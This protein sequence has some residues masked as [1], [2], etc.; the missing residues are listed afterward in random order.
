MD[1]LPDVVHRR[2]EGTRQE[3]PGTDGTPVIDGCARDAL[4][5]FVVVRQLLEP[6]QPHEDPYDGEPPGRC[7]GEPPAAE[8]ARHGAGTGHEASTT[9]R[10]GF[11]SPSPK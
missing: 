6:V 7:V 8:R 2:L 4:E 3:P 1:R 5:C 11:V 9:S 10:V